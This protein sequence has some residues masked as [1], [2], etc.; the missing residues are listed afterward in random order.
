LR[1]SPGVFAAGVIR[2]DL[3]A[4]RRCRSRDRAATAVDAHLAAGPE[5]FHQPPAGR[6]VVYATLL[7]VVEAVS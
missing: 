4:P 2:G 1:E 7:E 6:A 3:Q 5:D